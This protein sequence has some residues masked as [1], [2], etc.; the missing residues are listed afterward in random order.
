MGVTRHP[1]F[2]LYEACKTCAND[3]QK[4]GK[5][6]AGYDNFYKRKTKDNGCEKCKQ[7]K[8]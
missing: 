5:C 4:Y 7:K 6:K 3:V 8:R 2:H 1:I